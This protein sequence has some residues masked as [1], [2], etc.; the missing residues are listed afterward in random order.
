MYMID[1][2]NITLEQLEDPAQ[3]AWVDM[4]ALV[5]ELD[6]NFGWEP[7]RSTLVQALAE[8]LGLERD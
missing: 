1:K 6:I 7:D 4:K 8:E 2:D 5:D 3:S